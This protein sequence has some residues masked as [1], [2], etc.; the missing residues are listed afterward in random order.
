MTKMR[1]MF[2]STVFNQDV[3]NWNTSL[4]TD[5]GL[6][7]YASNQHQDLSS[8]NVDSVTLLSGGCEQFSNSG[9]NP[10]RLFELGCVSECCPTRI[11][12]SDFDSAEAVSG[13]EKGEYVH[14]ECDAGY[15]GGGKAMCMT[16][17]FVNVSEAA[18]HGESLLF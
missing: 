8:W 16:D 9:C 15:T 14:V 7:F 1:A 12:F 17:G 2:H 6:M 4:V 10:S 11:P 3:S 5:M 13:L 18:C